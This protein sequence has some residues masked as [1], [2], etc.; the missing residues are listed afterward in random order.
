ML[1]GEKM[2]NLKILLS[3]DNVQDVHQYLSSRILKPSRLPEIME[4]EPVLTEV[5][6]F[7]AV[8]CVPRCQKVLELHKNLLTGYSYQ[9]VLK[10]LSSQSL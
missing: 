10:S 3:Y 4:E 1:L 5:A 7:D 8:L 9:N 6:L 2:T